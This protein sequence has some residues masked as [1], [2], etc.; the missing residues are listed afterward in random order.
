VA[1][2]RSGI[3]RDSDLHEPNERTEVKTRASSRREL[4]DHASSIHDRNHRP[5]NRVSESSSSRGRRSRNRDRN[6]NDNDN[7]IG[8]TWSGAYESRIASRDD[9]GWYYRDK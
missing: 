3:T 2:G 1:V 8:S 5:E 4:K 7:D 6:D 9:L